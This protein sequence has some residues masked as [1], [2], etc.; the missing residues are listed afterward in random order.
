MNDIAA[1]I[2]TMD[3]MTTGDLAER[4]AKLHGQPCRTCH[5]AYLIRKIAWRIQA[6]AEGDL[7]QRARKRATELADDANNNTARLAGAVRQAL[8]E[9]QES[10]GAAATS[11]ETRDF[12][13]RYVGP[14]V[15]NPNGR[16]TR[17]EQALVGARADV[18]RSIA[19]ARSLPLHIREAFW[20]R[21]RK[22]A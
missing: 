22:V 7:S 9:A 12:I 14:M 20:D 2:A 21:F 4:Y 17:K 16:I 5:R 19:G 3:R 18:K 6:T 10:L 11:T 8:A 15:L 1:E 13:E